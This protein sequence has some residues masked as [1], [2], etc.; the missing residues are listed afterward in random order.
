VNRVAELMEAR[1]APIAIPEPKPLCPA[2]R[3]QLL[4]C[5]DATSL[6]SLD[7][8]EIV[9]ALCARAKEGPVAAVCVHSHFVG[10]AKRCLI[11][12]EV[13][14]ATVAGGFPH[15][16]MTTRAM[17]ADVE[18]CAAAGAEEI[19][20]V[21]PRFLANRGEW[22]ALAGWVGVAKDACGKAKLKV[23]LS[24]GELASHDTV[25]KASLACLCGGA[26]F[27]KTSTGKEKVNADPESSAIMLQ[28]LEAWRR[29]TGE[30]RGFKAAGGVGTAVKADVY[31]TIAEVIMGEKYVVPK[32]FR[33]GASALLS[34][35]LPR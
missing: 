4:S 9:A 2:R 23:I 27:L 3:L 18:A 10:S 7:T 20:I 33:I 22:E 16:L 32:R 5:L 35:L 25:W 28:A 29:L 19:D 14:V 15:G 12:S 30:T 1:P 17:S 34:E 11:G 21:I 13:K 8:P 24:T 6:D 26:D 31:A